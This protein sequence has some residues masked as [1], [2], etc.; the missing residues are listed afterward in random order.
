MKT[1][2]T[3]SDSDTIRSKCLGNRDQPENYKSSKYGAQKIDKKA[4][5][6]LDNN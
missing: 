4:L 6:F 3:Y 2:T 1:Q 5:S